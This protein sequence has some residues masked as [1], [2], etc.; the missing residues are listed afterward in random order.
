MAQQN[1]SQIQREEF[2]NS[3]LAAVNKIPVEEIV[4]SHVTLTPK[5]RY[6]MGL[7]PFHADHTLGSFVVTPDKGLWRCFAEGIGG[8]GVKFYMEFHNMPYLQ[9]CFHLAKEYGIITNEEFRKYSGKRWNKDTVRQIREKLE[10]SKA[11]SRKADADVIAAVYNAIPHV[12]PLSDAHEKHLRRVRGLHG[13]LNDFFTFPTRRTDLAGKV[14]RYIAEKLSEKKF[15]KPLR[16]LDTNEQKVITD[17]M[18]RVA[19]QMPYVPGFFKNKSTGKIDFASFRGI[20][21]V[22]RDEMGHPLGIQIRKDTLKEGEQRYIWF[23]S[24]FAQEQPYYEGGASSGAPGGFVS[25]NGDNPQIC[26]TEGRFKAEKIA[27]AGNHAVYVSG[28]S[29]WKEILPI[30]ERTMIRKCV[31]LMFDSDVLGNT[32]VHKQLD[33]LNKA[34]SEK[35]IRTFV[36]A[37]ASSNGKGFDDLYINKGQ[38]YSSFLKS[39]PYDRFEKKYQKVLAEELRTLNVTDIRDIPKEK[40]QEFSRNMQKHVEEALELKI[41]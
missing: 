38:N 33:S 5:G 35:G 4:G 28:V 25:G 9:A 17:L 20:G 22:V 23:S 31:F 21:I 40:A 8:N 27:E 30:V 29:T 18:Q 14:F 16:K 24:A 19:D 36:I 37:W 3:M 34:L 32:A 2:L 13:S 41:D 15:Q 6:L 12:C 26:I 1:R 39:M 7:C 11:P 10:E